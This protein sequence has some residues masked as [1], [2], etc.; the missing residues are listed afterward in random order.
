MDFRAVSQQ[1]FGLLYPA[2]VEQAADDGG[3]DVPAVDETLADPHD[4]QHT[5]S[6]DTVGVEP[7]MAE[8]VVVTDDDGFGAD[9]LADMLPDE[10]AARQGAECAVERNDDEDIDPELFQ[11][12]S[13]SV[14]RSE[15]AQSVA[16][17]QDNAR[18]RLEREDDAFSA[19]CP[20]LGDEAPDQSAVAEMDPVE[21]TDRDDG[22]PERGERS[23]TSEKAH[24]T[25][26][27]KRRSP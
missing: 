6:L 16:V 10:L 14:E 21:R 5:E 7:V 24:G 12:R 27:W 4:A 13:L 1:P 23:E 3:A 18:M 9:R 19:N 26:D 17:S 11:Q 2:L 8:A 25:T 22:M 20:G 15:N